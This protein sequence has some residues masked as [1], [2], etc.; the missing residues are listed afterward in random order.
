MTFKLGQ[1]AKHATHYTGLVGIY[2]IIRSIHISLFIPMISNNCRHHFIPTLR[3]IQCS[4][5]PKIVSSSNL[6]K[7]NLLNPMPLMSFSKLHSLPIGLS[8]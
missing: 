1:P 7:A 2:Y 6:A 4:D 3:E 5:S 8:C